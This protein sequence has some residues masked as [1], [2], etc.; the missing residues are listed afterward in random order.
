M[1][2]A[3][4]SGC[5]KTQVYPGFTRVGGD[6]NASYY[7][8]ASTI[9]RVS[10]ERQFSF[11]ELI[12]KPTAE[13]DVGEAIVDCNSLETFAGEMGHYNGQK[14]F[15]STTPQHSQSSTSIAQFVCTEGKGDNR[16][17]FIGSFNT[18][19]AISAVLGATD[20]EWIPSPPTDSKMDIL[21]SYTNKKFKASV[22]LDSA[23]TEGGLPMHILV[24]GSLPVNTD[25]SCH[26][27]GVLIS[28]YTFRQD[29][30]GWFVV[31]H[32]PYLLEG[33]SFGLA[34]RISLVK[35]GPDRTCFS[36]SSSYM[37]QGEEGE[38]VELFAPWGPRI[39]SAITLK[40]LLDDTGAMGG[41]PSAKYQMNYTF[42]PSQ[43]NG[44]FDLY[45]STN[46]NKVD[47]KNNLISANE[48]QVCKM[49]GTAYV[50][51]TQ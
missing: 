50:C 19:E 31:A 28:A 12:E 44:F 29:T 35:I 38:V 37:V 30:N 8:D 9:K 26:A 4:L 41:N 39:V 25:Y 51:L 43:T 23:Y 13:Y 33:G 5:R 14:H 1:L 27:C 32:E 40:T 20:S 16:P 3:H 42:G 18:D 11:I 21:G 45:L 22:L 49:K 36:V 10:A 47:D 6:G 24:L 46:G 17:L 2:T 48:T 7:V 15:I 34:P